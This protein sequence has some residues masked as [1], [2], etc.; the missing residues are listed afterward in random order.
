MAETRRTNLKIMGATNFIF[1][2]IRGRSREYRSLPFW[3]L[4]DRLD[5]DKMADQIREMSE[6][7]CGGYFMHARSGLLT[8]YM[9]KEWFECLDAGVKEGTARGL[10]SYVYDENGWPSGF[11]DGKIVQKH[12]EYRLRWLECYPAD[13]VPDGAEPLAFYKSEKG[14]CKRVP[15]KDKARFAVCV[16]TSPD[17]VDILDDETTDCFIEEVY[18]TYRKRYKNSIRGFF[19]DEPQYGKRTCPWSRRFAERFFEK[20]GYD[21]LDGLLCLFYDLEGCRPFRYDFY[22]LAEDMLC[23][24][25]YQKIYEWC[26]RY[27]Y[28]FTGHG[29]DENSL[30]G[31]VIDCGDIM[32][33]YEFMQMPGIDWLG[34]SPC[35]MEVPRQVSS[36]ARQ[37]GKPRVLTESFALCGWSVGLQRLRSIAERQYAGGINLLCQHL[38][39]YSLKG[40]RKRDY[41]PSHFEHQTWWKKYR[42]FNDYL[43]SLGSLLSAA[44]PSAELL[45]LSPVKSAFMLY[46]EKEKAS[47]LAYDREFSKT[48]AELEKNGIAYELGSEEILKRHACAKNGRLIV[49][50]RSYSAVLLPNCLGLDKNTTELLISFAETGGKIYYCG[51]FPSHMD[52]REAARSV[53]ESAAKLDILKKYSAKTEDFSVFL[54]DGEGYTFQTNGASVFFRGTIK[55]ADACRAEIIFAA[56]SHEVREAFTLIPREGYI[57]YRLDLEN[58]TAERFTGGRVEVNPYDSALFSVIKTTAPAGNIPREEIIEIVPDRREWTLKAENENILVLDR[59]EYSFDGSEYREMKDVRLLFSEL[60][61]GRKNGS[62]NM[63][64]FVEVENSDF[65]CGKIFFACEAHEEKEIFI[66]GR[67]VVW[68]DCGAFIDPCIEKTDVTGYIKTGRN[69]IVIKTYFEQSEYTYHV[70]NDDVLETEKNKIRYKT[71]LENCYLTGNFGVYGEGIQTENDSL[72]RNDLLCEKGDFVVRDSTEKSLPDEITQNGYPFFSGIMRCENTFR[73]KKFY[74]NTRYR[75][76]LKLLCDYAEIYCN[77]TLLWEGYDPDCSVDLTPSVTEG[78]NRLCVRLYSN[79]RNVFGPHHHRLGDPDFVGATA[80][81]D[82]LGWSDPPEPVWRKEYYFVPFGFEVRKKK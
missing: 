46:C 58:E 45:V 48:I 49:G 27:G 7:G 33:M 19:T 82:G 52:G 51:S 67:S 79:L 5:A 39:S 64:F 81:S 70:Y 32:R 3:S 68:K 54:S 20:Y 77:G 2:I 42:R 50:E 22:S 40:E 74:E 60:M 17:Y 24:A 78:K 23:G 61:H 73:V 28:I 63:R 30:S 59:G 43:T 31:L 41:P 71:E 56:N 55:T 69:E 16:R 53:G 18:E 62:L 47:V 26:A 4:N 35:P 57:L 12:P 1:D 6:K 36:V 13:A 37:L 76:S 11:A 66:N 10:D 72:L 15:T 34:R 75:F 65:I 9:G 14:V 29:F 80:F 44:E 8:D 25:Y 21:V 38:F